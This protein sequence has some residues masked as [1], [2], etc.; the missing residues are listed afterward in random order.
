MTT[1][2]MIVLGCQFEELKYHSPQTKTLIKTAKKSDRDLS[3]MG[4]TSTTSSSMGCSV[5]YLIG[6][7]FP[8]DS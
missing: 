5:D 1:A 7:F 8:L 6:L 2:N 4:C 3:S